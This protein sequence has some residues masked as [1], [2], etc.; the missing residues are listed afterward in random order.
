M[1]RKTRTTGLPR[2]QRRTVSHTA[3]RRVGGIAWDERAQR[4]LI[5]GGAGL[6]LAVILGLFA[7]K[8]Y[9]EKIG[10]PNTVVL[11]VEGEDF[12]LSYYADRLGGFIRANQGSNSNLQLLEEDLLNKLER[13]AVA[14]KLAKEKGVALDDGA[15]LDFVAGQL[16]VSRGGTAT[17]FDTLYRAQLR[18]QGLSEGNYRRLKRAELAETKLTEQIQAEVGAKGDQYV[19]R[20]ILLNTKEKADEIFAKIKGGAKIGDLAQTESLDLE[21]R[22]QDGLLLPE[23]LELFPAAIQA[24]LA[25]K[26][27]GDLLGP[28]QAGDN[29]WVFTIDR[30]EAI[31]YSDQQKGQLATARLDALV[32]K[33]RSDLRGAGKITS[34]LSSDD[35]TWAQNNATVPSQ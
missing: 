1:A 4:W 30:K 27:P 24:A 14:I 28:V 32:K 5:L 9:E 17:S 13:E 12:T 8:V 33:T 22:Q 26:N 3:S 20:T 23:P 35:L 6:L 34:S 2:Q 18:A 31:D 11:S 21:S 29:W 19:L 25:G 7:Y 16:G 10:R 15:V